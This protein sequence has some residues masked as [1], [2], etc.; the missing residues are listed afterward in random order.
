MAETDTSPS[1]LSI[2]EAEFQR[3]Q[4]CNVGIVHCTTCSQKDTMEGFNL[5]LQGKRSNF[6]E[7]MKAS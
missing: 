7:V 2:G 3:L 1:T 5:L 6:D 4:V